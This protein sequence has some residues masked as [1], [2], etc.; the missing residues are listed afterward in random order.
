MSNQLPSDACVGDHGPKVV[1]LPCLLHTGITGEAQES[2][3]LPWMILIVQP[4]LRTTALLTPQPQNVHITELQP[5][6]QA[7]P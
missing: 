1:L 7:R 4:R 3:K 2:L 6:K 5:D